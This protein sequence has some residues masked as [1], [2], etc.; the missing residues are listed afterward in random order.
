MDDNIDHPIAKATAVS[1]S[2]AVLHWPVWFDWLTDFGKFCA[3]I[4]AIAIFAELVW[5]KLIHPLIRRLRS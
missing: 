2:F 5:K 4:T 3:A 1:V